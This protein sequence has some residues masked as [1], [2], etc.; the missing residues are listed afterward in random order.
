MGF[1]AH[2]NLP[3][4]VR[5]QSFAR[6]NN[7]EGELGASVT[8]GTTRRHLRH[9]LRH[10]AKVTQKTT[11]RIPTTTESSTRPISSGTQGCHTF[12]SQ[13]P[14]RP[15]LSPLLFFHFCLPLLWS[16]CPPSCFPPNLPR[17]PSANCIIN[18]LHA[19]PWNFLPMS[20]SSLSNAPPS[21][22][23]F[24]LARFLRPFCAMNPPISDS[25]HNLLYFLSCNPPLLSFD[26]P[27]PCIL[28]RDPA[29]FKDLNSF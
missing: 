1:R 15:L 3:I 4:R 6:H 24:F 2:G 19:W 14:F 22:S 8:T 23:I 20:P 26:L 12:F 25:F 7:E 29:I 13:Q 18:Y 27:I 11:P 17:P 5:Q 21:C 16:P 28:G 10:T 9:T